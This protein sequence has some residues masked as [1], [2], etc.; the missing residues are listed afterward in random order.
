MPNHTFDCGYCRYCGLPYLEKSNPNNCEKISFKSNTH[1]WKF[2]FWSYARGLEYKCEI[3]D[4]D[5]VR[6]NENYIVRIDKD[7]TE[8]YTCNEQLML[9]A[10]E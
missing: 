10:N 2:H 3:C 7:L 6:V 8:F 5:G 1:K 9:K 4:I